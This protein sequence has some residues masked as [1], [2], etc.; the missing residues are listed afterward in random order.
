MYKPSTTWRFKGTCMSAFSCPL[1]VYLPFYS[2][3]LFS[4]IFIAWSDFQASRSRK[5]KVSSSLTV[6]QRNE[7]FIHWFYKSSH[8]LARNVISD[9]EM[10]CF[11]LHLL[12]VGLPRWWKLTDGRTEKIDPANQMSST[13]Q[14]NLNLFI[15][16][17]TQLQSLL[18][19]CQAQA[20]GTFTIENIVLSVVK[21]LILFP[22][23]LMATQNIIFMVV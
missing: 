4:F 2:N 16:M 21:R 18:I 17:L 10:P 7:P 8:I 20:F 15:V 23:E 12:N 14:W 11:T 1:L 3:L 9:K 13:K 6:V 19:N 5:I 22:C